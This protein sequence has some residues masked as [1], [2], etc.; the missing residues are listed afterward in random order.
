[1]V[2]INHSKKPGPVSF[3]I[4]SIAKLFKMSVPHITCFTLSFTRH[5]SSTRTS[6]PTLHAKGVTNRL[7]IMFQK[8][9]RC[10]SSVFST[11]A[12]SFCF[13]FTYAYF[14]KFYYTC[15]TKKKSYI[16]ILLLR[17]NHIR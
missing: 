12:L 17:S 9:P 1:M 2:S 14:M 5:S 3:V 13:Y 4:E 15:K 8:R 16:Y 7:N 10:S 11:I 6:T